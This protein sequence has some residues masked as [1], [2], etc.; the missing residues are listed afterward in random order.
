MAVLNSGNVTTKQ[1]GAFFNVTLGELFCLA[2]FA[3]AVAYDHAGIVSLRGQEG[4][5]PAI[6]ERSIS[7]GMSVL[8]AIIRARIENEVGV[9]RI[10]STWRF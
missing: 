3:E 4:K 2:H 7:Q 1:A 6:V 8:G 5:R 10:K 9:W